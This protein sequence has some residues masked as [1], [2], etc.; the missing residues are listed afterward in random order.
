MFYAWY[1]DSNGNPQ[2]I[3][4]NEIANILKS[5]YLDTALQREG[6]FVQFGLSNNDE[7]GWELY[8]Q[9][10]YLNGRY[11]IW[12]YPEYKSEVHSNKANALGLIEVISVNCKKF[13]H[14]C[15]FNSRFNAS[16]NCG[17]RYYKGFCKEV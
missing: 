14:R 1:N 3:C 11:E 2:G 13:A 6:H 12:V 17:A 9:I 7:S 5:D 8:A 15:K 16:P 10:M 4:G